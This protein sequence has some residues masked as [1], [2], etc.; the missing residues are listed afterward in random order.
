MCIIGHDIN[1]PQEVVIV[2]VSSPDSSTLAKLSPLISPPQSDEQNEVPA[3]HSED[4][5]L[6][7][8]GMH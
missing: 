3:C 8:A 4:N 1:L 2:V 6:V 7:C 5:G